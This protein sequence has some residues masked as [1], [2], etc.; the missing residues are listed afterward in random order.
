VIALAVL[1]V[2]LVNTGDE[3]SAAGRGVWSSAV[4]EADEG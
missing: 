2:V 3:W 4:V 1:L